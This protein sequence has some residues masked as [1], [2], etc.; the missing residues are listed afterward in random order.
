MTLTE[1]NKNAGI[2]A[3]HIAH[4][5]GDG[6]SEDDKV[7]D[8]AEL[9]IAPHHFVSLLGPSGCGKTT[10]LRMLHGLIVPVEG[11][12]AIDGRRVTK[13]TADR[14]M[15][16]QEHNLLP[17]R[18]VIENIEFACSLVGMSRADRE[19]QASKTLE[20]VGL[21]KF[22]KYYPHELSGGMKQRV[23]IARALA[24]RPD[25][26]LMDEPFGALD[27]QTRELMQI[28]L[29]RLWE[30]DRKTVVFVTHSIDE[31]ILLSDEIIVMTHRP[32]RVKRIVPIDLPRP[33]QAVAR[34]GAEWGRLRRVLWDLL[35]PEIERDA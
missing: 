10:L 13:P 21:A 3:R 6:R 35:S 8:V 32:G 28:E 30:T 7:L 24:I 4:W 33:R 1:T 2:S 15:V 9:D 31:S 20:Q 34:D 5:F 11:T 12:I 25:T 14:A 26:L 29:L 18:T 17:W 22:A 16:F 27:A 19:A 23:G